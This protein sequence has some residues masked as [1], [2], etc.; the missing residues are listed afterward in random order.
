M[1]KLEI[2]KG[3]EKRKPSVMIRQKT[4]TNQVL[5][6]HNFHGNSVHKDH[7]AK[8]GEEGAAARHISNAQLQPIQQL[9]V[10]TTHH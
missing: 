8:E 10:A 1:N 9:K 2:K 6:Q 4:T 3:E 7:P 5:Q